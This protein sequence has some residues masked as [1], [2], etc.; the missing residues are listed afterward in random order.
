MSSTHAV[1]Y[2]CDGQ[3]VKTFCIFLCADRSESYWAI[4]VF[5]IFAHILH[6]NEFEIKLDNKSLCLFSEGSQKTGIC[7]LGIAA[8]LKNR[9]ELYCIHVVLCFYSIGYCVNAPLMSVSFYKHLF[10]IM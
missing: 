2:T 7:H 6:H 5:M 1:Y 3:S 4:T 9:N 8:I 10:M